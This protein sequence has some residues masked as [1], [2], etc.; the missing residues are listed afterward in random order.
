MEE[1]ARNEART[2]LERLKLQAGKE[3][4]ALRAQLETEEPCPVCGSREHPWADRVETALR[5]GIE[6]QQERVKELDT[7]CRNLLQEKASLEGRNE[8]DRVRLSDMLGQRE[9]VEKHIANLESE[10]NA[11]AFEGKPD[12]S[13]SN[14]HVRSSL[15]GLTEILRKEKNRLDT[16]WQERQDL[17]KAIDLALEAREKL[18]KEVDDAARELGRLERK[19]HE[20]RLLEK[21]SQ[22]RLEQTVVSIEQA[23]GELDIPL[24]FL[25]GWSERLAGVEPP[26][27][28]ELKSL[29]EDY[30][31]QENTRDEERR[32]VVE[33]APRLAELQ[34]RL[35]TQRRQLDQL[36]KRSEEAD[37]KLATLRTRRGELLQGRPVELVET[38]LRKAV[39]G[40][41]QALETA[42]QNRKRKEKEVI[43]LSSRLEEQKRQLERLGAARSTLRKKLEGELKPLQMKWARMETLF[44]LPPEN[45]EAMR[46][47]IRELDQ[48]DQQNRVLVKE[49][50][51]LLEEHEKKRPELDEDSAIAEQEQQKQELHQHHEIRQELQLRLRRD[52]ENRQ[53]AGDLQ[54][55]LREQRRVCDTWERLDQLIGSA[56]GD[57]FRK[58]AQSLTL[59]ILVQH[60]NRHLRR[61]SRRYR[62][63][64]IPGVEMEM[65]VIDADLG[66]EARNLYG[67]SGGET[68]LVSLALALGM[69]SLSSHRV[70]VGSLFIDEGF[71]TLDARTLDMAIEALDAL[72]AQG[73]QVGVISHVAALVEGV[74]VQVRIHAHGGGRSI[75]EIWGS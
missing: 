3:A 32:V 11:L 48:D 26:L 44:A 5:K 20:N 54:Q 29:V 47:K 1:A 17:Q 2:T 75:L 72:Q 56:S 23:I 45:L 62:L 53:R 16:H 46:Q 14:R 64:R 49:R 67:L 57:R 42:D 28:D 25:P 43:R 4:A 58:F 41:E 22:A 13:L 59:D 7:L 9:N 68:F 73:R 36:G 18:G 24:A 35:D 70:Q 12:V 52:D 50:T 63:Q 69:S 33:L 61:L 15:S 10:W 19:L 74:R 65:Q 27:A 66:D 55:R 40:L 51:R 31:R 39:D 71:G 30:R 21:E 6:A 8:A 60:A 34:G 37:R 38:E